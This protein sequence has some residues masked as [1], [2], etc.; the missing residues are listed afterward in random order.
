MKS[1][2]L[3]NAHETPPTI[4]Q[5]DRIRRRICIST[6]LAGAIAEH[7]YGEAR[8]HTAMIHATTA[9]RVAAAT[10]AL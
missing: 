1:S 6:A 2:Y 3:T 4:L 5:A 10:G 7:A 8:D 9:A